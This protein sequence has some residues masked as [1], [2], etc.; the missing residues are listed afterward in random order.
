MKKILLIL[1]IFS[2]FVGGFVQAIA[3]KVKPSEIKIEVKPGVLIEQEIVIENPD[4]NVAF[5]EV[6]LDNFSS[7]IKAKPESFILESGESQ[8]VILE[9]KNKERGIF[10]TMISVVAKPLSERK[11]K[12]NSGVKI[13]LEVRIGE[14]EKSY[15]LANISQIFKLLLKSEIIIYIPGLLLILILTGIWIRRRNIS[16]KVD[17]AK[18]GVGHSILGK[19]NDDRVSD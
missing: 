1:I 11:F 17:V 16:K 15:F 6:Y 14:K 13:P 9:I 10:S 12:A 8:E 18:S 4:N 3:V 7:W 2:F 19:D 5:Y